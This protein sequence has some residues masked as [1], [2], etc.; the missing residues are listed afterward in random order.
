MMFVI[1]T[2]GER[3]EAAGIGIKKIRKTPPIVK[4]G[5]GKTDFFCVG[6]TEAPAA[7]REAG[8]TIVELRD[9]WYA[10]D[11]GGGIAIWGQGRYWEIRDTPFTVAERAPPEADAEPAAPADAD[12]VNVR[13]AIFGA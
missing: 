11:E 7:L 10:D 5:A 9:G 13:R 12:H 3:P 8:W 1:R 4:D 6:P 2:A